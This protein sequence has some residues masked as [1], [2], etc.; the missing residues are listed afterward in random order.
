MPRMTADFISE[1]LEVIGG[2]A[3]EKEIGNI[4]ADRMLAYLESHKVGNEDEI[5]K[6]LDSWI[7]EN[8]DPKLW[9]GKYLKKGL[10]L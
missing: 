10:K 8:A 5:R 6:V 9:F 1:R 3:H 2:S 4:T 7:D